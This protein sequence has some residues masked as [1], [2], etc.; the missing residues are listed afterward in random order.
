MTAVASVQVNTVNPPTRKMNPKITAY[1]ALKATGIA[2]GVGIVATMTSAYTD[3]MR[4]F[5]VEHKN[6]AKVTT[7][8]TAAHVIFAG[9]M[10]AMQD[11]KEK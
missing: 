9:A 1:S 7:V 3:K 4:L 11:K 2:A 6:Y 5:G 10:Y 8:L